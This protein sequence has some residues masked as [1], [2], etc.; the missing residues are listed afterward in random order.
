MLRLSLMDLTVET[1]D[2]VPGV[3]TTPTEPVDG[4]NT[5]CTGC[6]GC[7]EMTGCAPTQCRSDCR[8]PCNVCNFDAL[9]PR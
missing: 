4:T 8:T 2:L 6:A 7:S 5:G 1:F 3:P 9:E